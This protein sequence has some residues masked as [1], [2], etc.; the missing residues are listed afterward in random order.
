MLVVQGNPC[1]ICDI[2]LQDPLI[3]VNP[4]G[5]NPMNWS[6]TQTICLNVFD[7]FVGLAHRWLTSLHQS[8][9]SHSQAKKYD[10]FAKCR[11]DTLNFKKITKRLDLL[12]AVKYVKKKFSNSLRLKAGFKNDRIALGYV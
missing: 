10:A 9:N 6:N 3:Y 5:A 11:K 7:N 12:R 4:L 8:I 2:C 1:C